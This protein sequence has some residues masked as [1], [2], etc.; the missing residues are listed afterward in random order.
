MKSEYRA[1]PDAEAEE[2]KNCCATIYESDW[3]RLILGE[4][5]HPG[6]KEL[7]RKL[8]AALQLGQGQRV[9]DVASGPGI[10]AITLAQDFGCTVLGIDYGSA[11]VEQATRAAQSAGVAHLVT[12][13]QGDAECLPVADEAFDAVICECAFCTFP[14]KAQAASEFRRVLRPGGML[15]FSDLTYQG[16]AIPEA[17]QGLLAW[18][19]CIADALPLEEYVHYLEEAHLVVQQVEQCNDTLLALVREIQTRL[20]G[21][22]LLVKLKKLDLPGGLDF[23]QARAVAKAAAAAITAQ[24]FGYVVLI[25]TA[26]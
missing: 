16:G 17:L 3:A 25:A 6:G 18:I 7:T 22:E 23:E 8:G 19:A 5:F 2:R 20:L 26:S 11:A 10:S 24:Q 12:F 13:Q 14:Q 21:A 15:G 1:A 9:L 4:T